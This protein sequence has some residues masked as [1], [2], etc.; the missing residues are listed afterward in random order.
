MST[1]ETKK[2][3]IA[4]EALTLL[5]QRA[6]SLPNIAVCGLMIMPPYSE[7]PEN[8]RNHF[9]QLASLLDQIK[10]NLEKQDNHP[11]NQ[12]SMGMTGDFKVAIQE[13]ATLIRVGTAIFG[14]R[15][16]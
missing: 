7:N 11:L 14:N 16:V 12:L 15:A 8:S 9:R 6:M 13:G 10:T 2:S 4:P 5:L 1:G 3:G